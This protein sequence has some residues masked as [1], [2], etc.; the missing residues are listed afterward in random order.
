MRL[1]RRGFVLAALFVGRLRSEAALEQLSSSVRLGV[2]RV[3]DLVPG[4]LRGVRVR[5]PLRHYSLE[6][7]PTRGLEQLPAVLLERGHPVQGSD[8]RRQ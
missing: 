3:L 6:I 1:S 4:G 2:G 5:L 8:R 7:Q